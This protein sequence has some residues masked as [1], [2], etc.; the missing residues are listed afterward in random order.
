ML[1]AATSP[2]APVPVFGTRRGCD[3]PPRRRRDCNHI[4]TNGHEGHLHREGDQTPEAVSECLADR[5][6]E[7]PLMS[8]PSE[9]TTTAMATNMNAS[10]TSAR[11]MR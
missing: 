3:K 11:P 7:A 4:A 2:T 9:T 8:A 1:I 10:E 5:R 6:G